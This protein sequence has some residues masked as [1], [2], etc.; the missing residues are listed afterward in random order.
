MT[1]WSDVA[2]MMVPVL[3]FLGMSVVLNVLLMCIIWIQ[4]MCCVCDSRR[5]RSHGTTSASS[6]DPLASPTPLF[7]VIVDPDGG[8]RLGPSEPH[9]SENESTSFEK[10]EVFREASS[11]QSQI[12]Y[13]GASQSPPS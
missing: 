12:P 9:G 5:G 6:D 1:Q 10:N 8:I 4:F 2:V 13:R 11:S 3:F 7:V